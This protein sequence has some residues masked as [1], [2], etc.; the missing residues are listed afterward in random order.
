MDRA[1]AIERLKAEFLVSL[2][3]LDVTDIDASILSIDTLHDNLVDRGGVADTTTFVNNAPILGYATMPEKLVLWTVKEAYFSELIDTTQS[4][5][6]VQDTYQAFD[7]NPFTGDYVNL[8]SVMESWRSSTELFVWDDSQY[9]R[10]SGEGCT[11]IGY[12]KGFRRAPIPTIPYMVDTFTPTP[13][14][15]IPPGLSIQ[16]VYNAG[17]I[18]SIRTSASSTC[19]GVECDWLEITPDGESGEDSGSLVLSI[20]RDCLLC[21]DS[22]AGTPVQVLARDANGKL[23]WLDLDQC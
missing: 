20:N 4:G 17:F 15:V 16:D 3:D 7:P 2:A 14:I 13:S 9:I 21:G 10:A 18:Y 12:T 22:D 1:E 6:M 11:P 5:L 8:Y 19:G 23:K